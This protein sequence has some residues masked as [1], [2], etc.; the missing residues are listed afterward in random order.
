[1]TAP[2]AQGP[3]SSEGP[4]GSAGGIRIEPGPGQESVWDYPRPPRVQGTGERVVVELGG[5]VL[6]Q[7]THALR[8]LETSHPPVYYLPRDA[9]AP[10]ALEP[11]GGSSYCE[12]K[13]MARY[14]DLVGGDRR[15]PRAG[16]FY[17]D[18]EPGFEALR[19]H[20]AVYPGALD[21]CTVDGEQVT[22][23]AGGFYGGW[24]TSRVVGP[25]KGEPGT[26]KW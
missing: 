21:R 8:V 13:G 7:T 12:F 3:R 11:A 19:D 18:P 17:P 23:Q 10:G 2:G 4:R 14:L 22:A 26:L 16:W 6:A 24:I 15:A 1:M 9:F 25:F 20:V 5:V